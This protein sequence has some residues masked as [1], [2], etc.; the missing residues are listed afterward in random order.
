M[1]RRHLTRW[2]LSGAMLFIPTLA[3]AAGPRVMLVTGNGIQ[4]QIVLADWAE[5]QAIMMAATEPAAVTKESLAD[6]PYYD[7]AL[8]WGPEWAAYVDSGQSLAA[9]TPAHATQHGRLYPATKTAPA[10]LEFI[11][12]PDPE[13]FAVRRAGLFRTVSVSAVEILARHGIA[14]RRKVE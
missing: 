2:G 8:F 5:N 13:G 10:I 11:D 9:L 12:R 6:R 7:V 3:L 1:L 4:R 14:L